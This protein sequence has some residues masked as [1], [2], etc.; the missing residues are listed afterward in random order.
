[1]QIDKEQRMAKWYLL[2]LLG[3]MLAFI[4]YAVA[5]FWILPP[6]AKSLL[7]TNLSAQLHRTVS[8]ERIKINPFELTFS[9]KGFSIREL[10][11]TDNFV[12]FDEL[13]AVLQGGSIVE[14]ALILKEVRL[15]GPY[16]GISRTRDGR[17]NFIDLLEEQAVAPQTT[18]PA[19]GGRASE[20]GNESAA[21]P[22]ATPSGGKD[23]APSPFKFS[24]HNVQIVNGRVDYF[25]EAKGD[26]KSVANIDLE[27]PLISSL[28]EGLEGWT[29]LTVTAKLNESPV[30]ILAKAKLFSENLEAVVDMWV[31]RLDL[32]DYLAYLPPQLKVKIRSGQV[33]AE[34]RATYCQAEAKNRL[35]ITGGPP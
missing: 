9:I 33:D 24:V 29:G 34:A 14:R 19:P 22:P 3:I 31:E 30:S 17:F 23:Q 7:E 4:L 35:K 21:S 11:S 27:V 12:A 13:Y 2:F 5:G 28:E 16:V 1:M 20:P 10:N 32:T 8:I 15:S 26:K 18:P 25:D 6:I